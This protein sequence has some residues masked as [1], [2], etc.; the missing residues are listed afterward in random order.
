MLSNLKGNIEEGDGKIVFD[1]TRQN[2][3]GQDHGK[4]RG[5]L[6]LLLLGD[7]CGPWFPFKLML[8]T[9]HNNFDERNSF[10]VPKTLNFLPKFKFYPKNKDRVL[11][12]VYRVNDLVVEIKT[13][14][15]QS[16]PRKI[17]LTFLRRGQ[18]NQR[19]RRRKEEGEEEEMRGGG[20]VTEVM[21]RLYALCWD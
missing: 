15:R 6:P 14:K 20:K 17:Q 12:Q 16:K 7:L 11:Y 21:I 4:Q 8:N 5:A 13:E 19:R 10:I 9:G 3:T 1:T 2:T 18:N